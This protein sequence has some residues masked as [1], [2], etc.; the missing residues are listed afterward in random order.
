MRPALTI[1]VDVGSTGLSGQLC[2]VVRAKERETF[3]LCDAAFHEIAMCE[4]PGTL[5]TYAFDHGA[6]EVVH[7][8]DCSMFDDIGGD[9]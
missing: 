8:Y 2:M 9:R 7:T 3:V 5:A 6:K 1:L 4:R